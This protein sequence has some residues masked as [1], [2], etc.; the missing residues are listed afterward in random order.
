MKKIRSIVMIIIVF[1]LMVSIGYS[2]NKTKKQS[3]VSAKNI[4]EDYDLQERCGKQ[5]KEWF[6]KEWGS[7]NS[8][9]SSDILD[10][11]IFY[12]N[13]YNKKQNKCFVLLTHKI[14]SKVKEK[15]SL[16]VKSMIDINENNSY[17]LLQVQYIPEGDIIKI[18]DCKVLDKSCNSEKEWNKLVKPYMED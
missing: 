8:N 15:Y 17:G 13:H 18:M 3:S 9:T 4:K 1:V 11:N 14:K 10:V 2:E 6:E 5:S 12:S 7:E 16:T